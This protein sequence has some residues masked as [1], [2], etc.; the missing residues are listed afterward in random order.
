MFLDLRRLTDDGLLF[1]RLLELPEPRGEDGE[2]FVVG[3]ARL[4]GRA[5]PGARGVE[6]SARLEARLRLLCSRC[7][8]P[9][10]MDL[11]TEFHLRIV[12]DAVE[13]GVGETELAAEDATL[14]YAREEKADLRTIATEQ[15]Y[16]NLPLKPICREDCAGLCPTCGVNRNRIKCTCQRT[17]VDP[18]LMPLMD[19][20]KRMGRRG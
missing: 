7:L 5:S 3:R 9:H 15:V 11:D 2:R 12:A 14:F 4:A 8:E 16:L 1:D 10:A 17:E 13:F 20:K 6:L 19:L 18:R